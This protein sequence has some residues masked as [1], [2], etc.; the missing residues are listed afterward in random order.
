MDTRVSYAL[1][2]LFV[3]VL[4][5]AMIAVGLWLGAGID[6][7]TYARY[8]VYTTD[9]VSGLRQG[10]PVTYRG[11][12]VGT[13]ARIA[14]DRDNPQRIHLVLNV[15]AG[16]PVGADTVATLQMQGITGIGHIELSGSHPG[17]DPPPTPPGEPYPIIDY[18]PSLLGRL[19]TLAIDML[20][21]LQGLAD[22]LGALLSEENR[23]AVA[24]TLD[25]LRRI[26]ASFASNEGNLQNLLQR[27]DSLAVS[28]T[29][30]IEPLPETLAHLDTALDEVEAAAASVDVAAEELA[31]LGATAQ[32]GLATLTE[33]TLP[34]ANALLLQMRQLT[35]QLSAFSGELARDPSVLLFGPPERAPGP[36]E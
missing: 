26:S 18:R 6:D 21:T 3:I 34:A 1:V 9:S 32:T 30:A 23:A 19:D 35:Q 8:S 28:A 22:Q 2:G 13:V 15:A 7:T 14:I 5:A 36:G 12:G 4:T 31:E 33:R 20:N 29:R 11:V 24:E 25:N 16:T 17:G 10:S 27:L